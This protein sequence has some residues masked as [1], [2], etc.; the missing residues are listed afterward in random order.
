MTLSRRALLFSGLILSACQ[1]EP[2]PSSNRE[3]ALVGPAYL[4]G[5]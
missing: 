4:Q 3:A 1:A 5:A 2:D